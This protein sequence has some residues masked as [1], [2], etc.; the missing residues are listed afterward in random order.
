MKNLLLLTIFISTF[1]ANIFAQVN[2]DSLL[3]AY[4]PFNSN[5]LDESGNGNHGTVFGA[6]LADDRCGDD[7]SAYFFS[8]NGSYINTNITPNSIFSISIWYNK[9]QS[10][11]ENAGL[12]STYSGGFNYSGVYYAMNGTGDWIRCD[13]NSLDSYASSALIWKHIVIV[14]DGTKVKVYEDTDIKLEFNGTTNHSNSLVIGDSRYNGRY[15]S[16]KIDDIRIY[17]RVLSDEE[18]TLL[19][20]DCTTSI[21]EV[22]SVNKL[23]ISPNPFSNKTIINF[24]NPE[25]NNYELKINDMSGNLIYQNFNVNSSSFEFERNNLPSGV[26]LATLRGKKFFLGKMVVE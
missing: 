14:S 26:Y 17:N 9:D 6:T 12:F 16:G 20:E 13:G 21:K 2:L 1:S 8:G 10:Q 11:N 5:A 3:V 19:Y 18:I 24:D 23:D 4:Y 22:S 15:F 7:N 25:H